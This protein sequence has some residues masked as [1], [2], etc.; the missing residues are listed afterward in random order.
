MGEHEPDEQS[1]PKE[2]KIHSSKTKQVSL[3]DLNWR[4]GIE[5]V[6]NEPGGGTALL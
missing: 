4:D 3:C 5:T 6:P 1:R 2:H